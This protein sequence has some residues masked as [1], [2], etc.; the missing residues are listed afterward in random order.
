MA[1]KP[2]SDKCS[3]RWCRNHVFELLPLS[4]EL[5]LKKLQ[6]GQ[7]CPM[8]NKYKLMIVFRN[9]KIFRKSLPIVNR[10]HKFYTPLF[11]L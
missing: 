2:K 4:K 10:D 9:L 6:R 11:I 1:K 3:S 8:F 5:F 7:F